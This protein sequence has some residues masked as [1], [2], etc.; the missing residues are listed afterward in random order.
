MRVTGSVHRRARSVVATCLWMV[1]AA[2]APSVA[3]GQEVGARPQPEGR[4]DL[5]AGSVSAV[6]AGV[7]VN[8]PAGYYARVGLLAAAGARVSG[9]GGASARV[10]AIARFLFDPVFEERWGLSAGGGVSVRYDGGTGWRP[11][12]VVVVDLEAPGRG[13]VIPAVQVGL[14]GG[15]RVGVALR[16]RDGRRR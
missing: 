12:L 16:K 14:G 5:I 4:L 15:V 11:F 10:D 13:P 7:G 9:D 2:V 1:I 8:V 3:A 6:H